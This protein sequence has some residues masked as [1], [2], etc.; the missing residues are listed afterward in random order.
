MYLSKN[1]RRAGGEASVWLR[2][3]RPTRG[4]RPAPHQH[5]ASI[6][7]VP[8]GRNL[9]N[10]REGFLASSQPRLIYKFIK[11]GW[12]F[13][14]EFKIRNETEEHVIATVVEKSACFG[15]KVV[16][17]GEV[18]RESNE[19]NATLDL[20]SSFI[21]PTTDKFLVLNETGLN[22]LVS[23]LTPRSYRLSRTVNL[24]KEE[25]NSTTPVSDTVHKIW[26]YFLVIDYE[27]IGANLGNYFIVMN[28]V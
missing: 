2:P 28:V 1:Q 27:V 11:G 5:T 15:N 20:E 8:S 13:E 22:R 25:T 3:T 19:K 7:I 23:L 6:K 10:D 24:N 9:S 21:H 14:V 16:H 18:C 12:G 26:S 4:L 17:V